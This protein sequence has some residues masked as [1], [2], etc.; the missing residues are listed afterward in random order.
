MKR[1]GVFKA[2]DDYLESI[3]RLERIWSW[4][5]RGCRVHRVMS[6]DNRMFDCLQFCLI[7]DRTKMEARRR[8]VT[9]RL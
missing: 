2:Q 8:K 3:W 5:T 7:R 9:W 1:K 6:A 4:C